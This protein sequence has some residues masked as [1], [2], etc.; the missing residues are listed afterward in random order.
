MPLTVSPRTQFSIGKFGQSF[1]N[2]HRGQNV[3]SQQSE[4]FL[5]ES[6]NFIGKGPFSPAGV[7]PCRSQ[8]RQDPQNRPYYSIE[9]GTDIPTQ[10]CLGEA[11]F[12]RFRDTFLN[13]IDEES[14]PFLSTDPDS[15]YVNGT[16]ILN[17]KHAGEKYEATS[18]FT[19]WKI[20]SGIEFSMAP[21][22]YDEY[23]PKQGSSINVYWSYHKEGEVGEQPA[24]VTDNRNDEYLNIANSI[25]IN[26]V[27][28]AGSRIYLEIRHDLNTMDYSYTVENMEGWV[29][30][31]K[32]NS[33]ILSRF[34][35]AYNSKVF[36]NLENYYRDRDSGP[37]IPRGRCTVMFFSK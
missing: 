32:K 13:P 18:S 28:W 27:Y 37:G 3:E 10:L 2:I 7:Y 23:Y 26:P 31:K 25:G 8:G 34:V 5:R 36:S 29:R 9:N 4:V 35:S 16:D 20:V 14:D 19:D 15:D 22:I 6:T 30:T 24:I 21:D 17:S 1:V 11:G 33:L 12:R